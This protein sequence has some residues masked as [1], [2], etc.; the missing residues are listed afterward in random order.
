MLPLTILILTACSDRLHNK[1][2]VQ[3]AITDRL[4]SHSGLDLNELNVTTTSVSYDKN[5]AYATVAFHPKGDPSV[6]SGMTM[7]YT[8]EEQ[9]GKWVVINVGEGQGHGAAGQG[10]M[11][12][13]ALPPGHPQV[14]PNLPKP[15][16][17]ESK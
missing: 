10:G 17:G 14:N 4:Q 8:L 7:K 3:K 6:N 12:G 2:M 13:S 16:A 11:N 15:G 9:S 5:K 1:E